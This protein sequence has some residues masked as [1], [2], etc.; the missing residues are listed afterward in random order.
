MFAA[1]IS[2]ATKRPFINVFII[3]NLLYVVFH[4]ITQFPPHSVLTTV[5]EGGSRPQ[6]ALSSKHKKSF[7]LFVQTANIMRH[8][9]G[10]T[11]THQ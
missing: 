6:E 5:K 7:S 9:G 2:E 8:G 10:G 3:P 4:W 1:S 11:S